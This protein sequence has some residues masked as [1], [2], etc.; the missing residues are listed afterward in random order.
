MSRATNFSKAGV[1]SYLGE[2]TR[3]DKGNYNLA[4][5]DDFAT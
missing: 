3:G 2:L 4:E 1:S 5:E